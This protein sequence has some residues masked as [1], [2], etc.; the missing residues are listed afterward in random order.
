MLQEL[1][2]IQINII[3]LF[4]LATIGISNLFI[5]CFFGELASESFGRMADSLYF[6]SNWQKFST[7]LQRSVIIITTNT[8][9]P[10]YYHGFGMAVL[11]LETATNVRDFMIFFKDSSK[12]FTISSM[13][14]SYSRSEVF[15]LII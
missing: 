11:K 8:Q 13:R 1:E 14:I 3:Y 9:R 12:L 2:H 10:L 4:V 15:I 7:K 6:D 5:Y